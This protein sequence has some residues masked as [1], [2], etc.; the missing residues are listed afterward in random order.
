MLYDCA[1]HRIGLKS[2][3][4]LAFLALLYRSLTFV[5]SVEN[6]GITGEAQQPFNCAGQHLPISPLNNWPDFKHLRA[7][8]KRFSSSFPFLP[9]LFSFFSPSFLFFPLFF[10][11]YFCLPFFLSFF[12]SFY[13]F[14]MSLYLV[15]LPSPLTKLN[16][17][18]NLKT[19]LTA[20]MSSWI[21]W[22]NISSSRAELKFICYS[23]LKWT[24][25][26]YAHQ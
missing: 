14:L 20:V 16:I 1:P 9:S 4:F 8:T 23:I 26:V 11:L 18:T 2:G 13:L 12:P 25:L 15:H 10:F 7:W 19:W 24:I 6:L 21:N 5:K 22:S 17:C 3:S